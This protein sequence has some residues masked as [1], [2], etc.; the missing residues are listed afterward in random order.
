MTMYMFCTNPASWYGY[1]C[2]VPSAGSTMMIIVTMQSYVAK[3]CPKMIRG[4]IYAIIGII[5]SLGMIIYISLS[6]VLSKALGPNWVFGAL[7]LL[8]ALML[9]F[10]LAMIA[11]GYYGIP[12]EIN[13]GGGSDAE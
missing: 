6:Q 4:T 5:G 2:V 13:D 7:G 8:D 1:L 3:R 9:L 12:P 10:L 11:L